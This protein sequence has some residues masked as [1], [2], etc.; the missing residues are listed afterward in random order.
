[1]INS[2]GRGSEHPIL[3]RS[4]KEKWMKTCSEA[5]YSIFRVQS[6]NIQHFFIVHISSSSLPSP[7]LPPGRGHRALGGGGGDT[8]VRGMFNFRLN[9]IYPTL[10]VAWVSWPGSNSRWKRNKA[11]HQVKL[12]LDHCSTHV[13]VSEFVILFKR[14]PAQTVAVNCANFIYI[15]RV[16]ILQVCY[17]LLCKTYANR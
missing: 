6:D 2:E 8:R 9:W 13:S 10:W 11:R 17:G 3:I 12:D 5:K 4:L 7:P 15:F 16:G 14:W 1:M